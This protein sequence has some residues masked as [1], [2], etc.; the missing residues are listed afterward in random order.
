MIQ[1]ELAKTGIKVSGLAIGTG[2]AGKN[3]RPIQKDMSHGE[4]AALLLYAYDRGITFWDTARAYGTY[5][6]IREAL[7]NVKRDSITITTK[8]ASFDSRNTRLW[9]EECLQSLG[10][11][12]VDVCLMHAVRSKGEFRKRTAE[13]ETMIKMKKEGKIRAVGLSSHGIEALQMGLETD[14]IEVV[15]GRINIAG[16]HMDRD[17]LSLYDSLATIPIVRKVYDAIPD[18]IKGLIHT[19][20]GDS[21]ISDDE[22]RKTESLLQDIHDASKGIVGMKVMGEGHLAKTAEEAIKFA[23]SKAYLDAILIGMI[24]REEIDMNCRLA[25]NYWRDKKFKSLRGRV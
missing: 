9:L 21:R 3:G 8:L 24:S 13:L 15:W 12:Y 1:V 18:R 23:L 14:E 5:G 19:N 17:C 11:D 25:E 16:C 10:T 6:H 2:T 22:Y 7:K 4:L 20:I